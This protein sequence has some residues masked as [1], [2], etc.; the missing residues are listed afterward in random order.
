MAFAPGTPGQSLSP[1]SAQELISHLQAQAPPVNPAT[2]FP[3]ED[4]SQSEMLARVRVRKS[5]DMAKDSE[6]DPTK[7]HIYDSMHGIMMQ[8]ISGA[9]GQSILQFAQS[10]FAPPPIP[11]GFQQPGTPG[12][13]GMAPPQAVAPQGPPMA[14]PAAP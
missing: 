6:A 1:Q 11:Q 9:D 5:I 14:A 4:Q 10:T 7:K 2:Q 8:M 3:R 12:A 13:V